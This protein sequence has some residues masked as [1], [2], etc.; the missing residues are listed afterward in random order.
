MIKREKLGLTALALIVFGPVVGS[1]IVAHLLSESTSLSA[2]TIEF[3]ISLVLELA[4]W[5]VAIV[6]FVQI[7]RAGRK[8][9]TAK[10]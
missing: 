8:H 7:I 10:G 5:V 6:W 2:I 4:G 9:K 3:L 1:G